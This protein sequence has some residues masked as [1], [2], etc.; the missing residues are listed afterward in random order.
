MSLI[1][2]SNKLRFSDDKVTVS[3]EGVTYKTFKSVNVV[4]TID[5]VAGSFS[6]AISKPSGTVK[7]FKTGNII[8]IK[9]DGVQ[10]MRGKIYEIKVIGDSGNKGILLSGRDI[11]GDLIDSSVPDGSKVFTDGVTLIAI[12]EKIITSLGLNVVMRVLD[13]SGGK[14]QPFSKVEIVSCQVGDTVI[15]FLSKY[16][17]KRQLFLN[18]DAFSNLILFK[19]TGEDT[20]NRIIN[21]DIDNE[22]NVISY[23]VKSNISK[24]FNK[25]ICKVQDSDAWV[26]GG[27][28]TVDAVGVAFDPA[29]QGSRIH[30]FKM[31]EESPS[32][33]ECRKRA[34]EESNVR[35]A[36]GFEYIV[37]VQG[38]KDKVT[39]AVNQFVTVSDDKAGVYGVFLIKG[40]E[41]KLDSTRGRF[42]KLTIVTKDAY[43]AEAAVN[44]RTSKEQN[45]GNKWQSS[46]RGIVEEV[47]SFLEKDIL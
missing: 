29:I 43:T 35:R 3:V 44:L 26:G 21:Q 24:R 46:V 45:A 7:D 13:K 19:A 18:T 17:R 38:F 33:E 42:T 28:S 8:F 2:N 16:C 27:D 10:V 32:S 39:W 22:N 25:Y 47:K 5:D 37:T 23:K 20:G 34:A 15:E 11:T 36:R 6:V 9:L 40:V 12:A 14:I 41:F 31:E 1:R 4:R 30:E